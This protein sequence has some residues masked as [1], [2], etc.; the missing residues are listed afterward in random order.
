MV[1]LS[2][3]ELINHVTGHGD[4]WDCSDVAVE[5]LKVTVADWERDIASLDSAI[6]ALLN[7]E[8]PDDNLAPA[9]DGALE[10]SLFSRQLAREEEEFQKVLREIRNRPRDKNLG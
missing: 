7:V 10:G 3:D 4:A 1:G 9:L 6:L 8:T 5:K 2:L